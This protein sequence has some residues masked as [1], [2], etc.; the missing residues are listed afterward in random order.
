MSEFQDSP[1]W[2]RDT[3]VISVGKMRLQTFVGV[4]LAQPD[5]QVGLPKEK[6]ELVSIIKGQEAQSTLPWCVP[7][8]TPAAGAEKLMECRFCDNLCVDIDYI[9]C[10]R[11]EVL[12]SDSQLPRVLRCCW[13]KVEPHRAVNQSS[14]IALHQR[15]I[16]VLHSDRGPKHE[17]RISNSIW[18]VSAVV[19][20]IL[21]LGHGTTS[22]EEEF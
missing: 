4:L 19:S 3:A 5:N 20:A 17:G 11:G 8:C 6:N 9:H 22:T 16:L 18:H 14:G 2:S 13:R 1:L 10:R 12:W 7:S 21:S 15:V